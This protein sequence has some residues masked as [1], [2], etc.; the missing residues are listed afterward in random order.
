MRNTKRIDADRTRSSELSTKGASSAPEGRAQHERDELSTK[1]AS[2]LQRATRHERGELNTRWASS[3][4]APNNR[5]TAWYSYMAD[6]YGGDAAV[7]GGGGGG[8]DDVDGGR[9]NR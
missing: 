2:Q 9:S 5:A 4:G 3:A 1:G 6:W 8:G 7:V